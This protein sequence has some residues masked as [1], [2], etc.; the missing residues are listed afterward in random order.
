MPVLKESMGIALFYCTVHFSAQKSET[1][2]ESEKYLA[3]F[4]FFLIHYSWYIKLLAL[5]L[6]TQFLSHFH[7]S[8]M[9]DAI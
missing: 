5:N 8:S 4:F 3:Y 2:F 6:F 7:V 9:N 1:L